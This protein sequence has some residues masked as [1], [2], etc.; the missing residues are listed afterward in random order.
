MTNV[1]VTGSGG[2]I[3]KNL[4]QALLRERD[5]AVRT[6]DVSD[7]DS[8]LASALLE[9]DVVYHL[10][11][12]NRPENEEEFFTGN[13]GLTSRI[14]ETLNN[15]KKRPLVV[16][17]SSIQAELDN[18]YGQSK[19]MAEKALEGF[20]AD[21]GRSVVFRLPN[22]FGKW[23]RPNY[24]SV[25]ATFCHN[26][27][28]NLPIQ[29]SDPARVMDLVYVDDVVKAFLALLD[30]A[31]PVGFS[32][33]EVQPVFHITLGKLVEELRSFESIRTGLQLPDL[34]NALR[35][36]LFATYTSFL[37]G[38]GLNYF[39]EK[40]T[41]DRGSLA[42]LLKSPHFGQI[43]VSRTRPGVTR[44]NHWHDTKV[45]KFCVIEGE[46]IIRFRD[47]NSDKPI[48]YPVRGDEF[49]VLD[50][51]PGYTHSI[52]NIGKGEMVVLFWSSEPFDR[53]R[54][55]THAQTVSTSKDS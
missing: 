24:N 28:R 12:V 11:G 4:V 48:E 21:G 49:Q 38:N 13:S 54:P 33:S 35:R 14:V 44:G 27:A 15:G 46:A 53:S 32:R 52:E 45:E 10:A 47:V 17:A 50:I 26:I 34:D 40:R 20:A 19:L 2:F 1:V 18:A 5:V 37:P 3:G 36:N 51:P 41:D 9:A 16:L 39:L 42:E 31:N 30:G 23:S 43:F 29:V 25:V 8:S 6:F 55:D 7:A 22:V